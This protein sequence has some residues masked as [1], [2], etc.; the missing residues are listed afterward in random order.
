MCVWFECLCK[1]GNFCCGNGDE[2]S[3][4]WMGYG[5]VCEC[6]LYNE[7]SVSRVWCCSWVGLYGEGIWFF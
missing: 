2:Y 4:F 1:L 6:I 3:F 7:E 5:R